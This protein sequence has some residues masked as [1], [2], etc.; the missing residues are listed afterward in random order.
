[1]EIDE[2]ALKKVYDSIERA[3]I[4]LYKAVN[5]T[6]KRG[7][8]P[9]IILPADDWKVEYSGRIIKISIPDYPPKTRY[10]QQRTKQRWINNVMFAIRSIKP[11]PQFKKV[12]VLVAFYIPDEDWDVDNRDVSP[13][14]NGIRYSRIVQSDSYQHVSYGVAGYYSDEPHTDIYIINNFEPLEILDF[15][16]KNSS[17]DDM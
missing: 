14:I 5:Y 17:S 6:I 12:F 1:M 4:E 15:I 3:R 11:L 16:N 7:E 9:E 13:I 2:Q 8:L 10:A